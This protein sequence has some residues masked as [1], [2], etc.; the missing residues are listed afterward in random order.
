MQGGVGVVCR[1]TTVKIKPKKAEGSIRPGMAGREGCVA[2]KAP[3]GQAKWSGQGLVP[4]T[5]GGVADVMGVVRRER[6]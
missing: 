4:C 6:R 3:G 2:K 5:L 1:G